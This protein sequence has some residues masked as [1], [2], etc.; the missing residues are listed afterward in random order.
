MAGGSGKPAGGV[1]Q[2]SAVS[3]DSCVLQ[4]PELGIE[5]LFLK[6]A[7]QNLLAQGWAIGHLGD[8]LRPLLPACFSLNFS[9]LSC[10][11]VPALGGQSLK[12][13]LAND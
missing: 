1:L 7:F 3:K 11:Q 10:P 9:R 5:F 12:H 6:S 2:S 8:C 13:N 4:M